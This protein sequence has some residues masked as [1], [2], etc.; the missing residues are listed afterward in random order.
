[1]TECGCCGKCI[2]PICPPEAAQPPYDEVSHEIGGNIMSIKVA[3]NIGQIQ[4]FK[5]GNLGSGQEQGTPR[6]DASCTD[7]AGEILV[8]PERCEVHYSLKKKDRELCEQKDWDGTPEC[9]PNSWTLL[10][11][12]VIGA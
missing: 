9:F 10:C 11:E 3:K 8:Q 5:D 4:A 6:F 2:H 12:L 7:S 1:M